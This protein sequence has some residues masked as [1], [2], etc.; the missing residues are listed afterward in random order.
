ME[1]KGNIEYLALPKTAFFCSREAPASVVL[2]CY[3]W[4]TMMRDSEECV[5]SGFQSQLEKDV[6][7]FL[8][9]GKHPVILVLGRAIY[10]QMP[11]EFTKPLSENRLLIISPVSQTIGRH[12]EQ[13][14]EKRNKYIMEIAEKIVFGSLNPQGKLY[15]IY[16]E[17]KGKGKQVEVLSECEVNKRWNLNG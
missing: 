15:P 14:I 12:S 5:I 1:T 7:H 3:D 8:L 17:A 16:C 10:K 4:A 9:K 11:E 6:F 13:T 2:K